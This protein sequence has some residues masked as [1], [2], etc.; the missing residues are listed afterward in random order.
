MALESPGEK[1]RAHESRE[2]WRERLRKDSPVPRLVHQQRTPRGDQSR[3]GAAPG[4]LP[5]L[6]RRRR[7]AVRTSRPAEERGAGRVDAGR[8]A[9]KDSRGN[10]RAGVAKGV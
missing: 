1:E 6:F 10:S 4:E 7:R 5:R 8:T 2:I 3:R 9:G